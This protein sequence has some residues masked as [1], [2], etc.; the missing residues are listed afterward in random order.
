MATCGTNCTITGDFALLEMHRF[1]I[2]RSVSEIDVTKLGDDT[3]G[4]AIGCAKTGTI[5]I[6]SYIRP[7]WEPGDEKTFACEIDSESYSVPAVVTTRSI[8]VD[9]N[10]EVSFTTNLR[11]V[12]DLTIT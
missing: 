10:G 3:F 6:E 11:I 7:D 2:V 12:G 4:S 8:P 9:A 1:R 5:T